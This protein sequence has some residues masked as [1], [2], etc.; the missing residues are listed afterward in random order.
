MN[1]KH[2]YDCLFIRLSIRLRMQ[3][4]QNVF[5]RLSAFFILLPAHF[6][7]SFHFH[8]AMYHGTPSGTSYVTAS[9]RL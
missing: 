3:D 6:V 9:C 8:V 1:R 7:T 2:S 4:L 5:Q